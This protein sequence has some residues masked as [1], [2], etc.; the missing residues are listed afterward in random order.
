MAGSFIEEELAVQLARNDQLVRVI[1][2]EGADLAEPRP[3]D[4]FF[5]PST[6]ADAV[7]LAGDLASLG[8]TTTHIADEEQDGQWS[9]Q[10]AR[11]D[12]VTAVTE[13]AFVEQL[14]RVAAKYL[15]E[16]DG[17]GTAV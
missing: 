5:Y 13:E 8:F 15:A 11:T 3:I 10:V 7:A 2:R 1:E 6:R 16:F 14:V 12:S 4:F 17:W 9:V